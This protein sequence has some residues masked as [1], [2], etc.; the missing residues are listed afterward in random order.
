MTPHEFWDTDKEIEFL[1][2]IGSYRE[3]GRVSDR[4][5]RLT[6]LIKYQASLTARKVWD[7]INSFRLEAATRLMIEDERE[8]LNLKAIKSDWVGHVD[9]IEV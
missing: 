6:L 5:L 8:R 4:R 9:G 3:R 1:A 7:R 2:K